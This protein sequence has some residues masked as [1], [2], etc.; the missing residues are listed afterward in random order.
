MLK[1]I[2]SGNPEKKFGREIL[3]GG[4]RGYKK[5]GSY[6]SSYYDKHYNHFS[7]K[8][9]ENERGIQSRNTGAGNP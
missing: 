3:G 7:L 4:L 6:S 5:K 9:G 8:E 2:S 1:L